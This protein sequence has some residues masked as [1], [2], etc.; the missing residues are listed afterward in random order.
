MAVGVLFPFFFLQC[1]LEL[2]KDRNVRIR[3]IGR[4]R[5]G[6]RGGGGGGGEGGRRGQGLRYTW[7]SDTRR[8]LS[9]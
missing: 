1:L 3:R 8:F 6:G 5:I 7:K 2:W 9:L 4:E